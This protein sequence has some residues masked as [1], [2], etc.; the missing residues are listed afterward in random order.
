[1]VLPAIVMMLPA[2]AFV[3]C[4]FEAWTAGQ[5]GIVTALTQALSFSAQARL[6]TTWANSFRASGPPI[7]KSAK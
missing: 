1:M 7:R 3:H 4:H 5:M 6:G 2:M